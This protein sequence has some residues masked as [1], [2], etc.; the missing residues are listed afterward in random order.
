[1]DIAWF[2]EIASQLFSSWMAQCQTHTHKNKYTVNVLLCLP[3]HTNTGRKKW[4]PGQ[5][6]WL[7][8]SSDQR[9]DPPPMQLSTKPLVLSRHILLIYKQDGK[10]SALQ[11]L[12]T[13]CNDCR[14]W[15]LFFLCPSLFCAAMSP[16][17]VLK[18]NRT[19]EMLQ[20]ADSL[21]TQRRPHMAPVALE[22]HLRK[23]CRKRMQNEFLHSTAR[24]KC[25]R[26]NCSLY[27]YL[28]CGSEG[29]R[30]LHHMNITTA[31]WKNREQHILI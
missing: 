17:S 5:R 23:L 4:R 8:G 1:M 30:N 16:Y 13:D 12:R 19:R 2:S 11:N 22:A 9:Q 24:E 21:W 31:V 29:R 18:P 25:H 7:D 28:P 27:Y 14:K 3:S 20:R 15:A 10:L 6:G 26:P